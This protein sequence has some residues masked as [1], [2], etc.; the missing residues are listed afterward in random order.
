MAASDSTEY[1]AIR[2]LG[3]ERLPGQS[4]QNRILGL[5][6]SEQTPPSGFIHGARLSDRHESGEAARPMDKPGA[7][8]IRIR[9]GSGGRVRC[10]AQTA[11]LLR[12]LRELRE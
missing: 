7:Q 10:R 2:L 3:L 1:P 9:E 11:R 12:E 8:R 6:L 5:I 4:E